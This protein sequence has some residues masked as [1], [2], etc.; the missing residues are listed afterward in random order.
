MVVMTPPPVRTPLR[1]AVDGWLDHLRVERGRSDH[2]LSAY[3]RDTGRY[4]GFLA[5]QGINAP[6]EVREDHVSAF[7]AHL[8]AGDADHPPLAATSAARAVVAVR[9][10]HRFL[11]VE[12]DSP[13]DPAQEVAPPPPPRRLPK[14]LP[15]IVSDSPG[16]A[17]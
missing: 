8:R 11:V 5:E 1:R 14:A 4:L 16:S 10:L 13:A 17:P 12:G 9:G 3:R 6:E 2:T 7:L 15:S